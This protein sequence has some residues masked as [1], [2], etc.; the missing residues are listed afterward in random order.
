LD[1]WI[2]CTL[3]IHTTPDY[4]Q[5]SAV[6]I[7]HTF[8]FAFTH[9]LGFSLFTS[10]VLATDFAQELYQFHCKCSTHEVFV[11]QPINFLPLFCSCQFNSIPLLPSSYPG[12]PASRKLIFH[13][14][15]DYCSELGRVLY[16]C[17]FINPPHGLHRKQSL[18]IG[19]LVY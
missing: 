7:L 2:Y 19:R 9:A 1:N 15:L 14:R 17:P 8:K 5:C 3:Y 4:K 13:S 11:S 10:R 18:L 16:L 6:A 12:R